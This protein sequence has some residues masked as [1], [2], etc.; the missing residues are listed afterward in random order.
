MGFAYLGETAGGDTAVEQT[1]MAIHASSDKRFPSDWRSVLSS[2]R[3]STRVI[4]G[5]FVGGMVGTSRKNMNS[6]VASGLNR[7][8][9]LNA[10]NRMSPRSWS[11]HNFKSTVVAFSNHCFVQV[12]R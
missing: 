1:L 3:N 4:V 9:G 6:N 7:G 2:L 12:A 10:V 11:S 5:E 8:M